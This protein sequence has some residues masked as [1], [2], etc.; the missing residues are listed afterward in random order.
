MV[1]RGPAAWAASTAGSRTRIRISASPTRNPVRSVAA[2]EAGGVALHVPCRRRTGRFVFRRFGHDFRRP[3]RSA[4]RSVRLD[5][6]EQMFYHRRSTMTAYAELHCHTNFSFLD[7]ASAPDELAERAAELGLSGPGGHRPPGP[8]RRRPRPRRRTRRRGSGRSSGSRSSCATRSSPDPDRVVVPARRPVRRGGAAAAGGRG[9]DGPDEPRRREGEP[10]RPRPERARLPG[11]SRG[12]Q[13]GPP[14]D[15]RAAA[16]AAPR[17]ARP[18]RDRLSEP[19]PARLAGEPRRDEGDAAVRP[20]AAR[21]AHRGPGRPVGLSRGRDRAAAAGRRPRRGAGGRRGPSPSVYGADRGRRRL[22]PRARRTTSCPTTTG[23]WPRRRRSPTSSGLPVVV[24]NDV[25]YA[26]PEGREFQDVLTAIRHGR[27]LDGL[28]DLRRPGR[29]VVPEVRRRRWRRCR[30]ATGSLGRARRRGPGRRG[31]TRSVE[32]AA[33][34]SGRPRLRAV[35]LPGLP[36][37]E[38]ARRRSRTSRAVLGGRAEAL[39]PADLGRRQPA[40][41][42]ARRDRAGR[43]RRVLPD[44]LGPDAVREGA[45]D[46]GPGPGQRRQLDRRLHPRDQPGRADPAQPAVRAVHQRGPD[47]LPGRRHRL[48][49]PRG[50]RRSSSTSTAATARSTRGW[51]ATS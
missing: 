40:R 22:P 7:G 50:G 31:W 21:R 43:A 51:S 6:I 49:A 15:R 1:Q 27:T 48:L 19:V 4:D 8:L 25:H 12:G 3:S 17:P 26:R 36:G 9:R 42:R 35:P 30:R 20:R 33:T 16:R 44:L 46:P 24:T 37:A 41:P 18:R 34:C 45:G 10:D 47:D 11:P 29:R 2:T 38:R 5:Q 23:S 14:R 28:A 39:S 32:L 13:G